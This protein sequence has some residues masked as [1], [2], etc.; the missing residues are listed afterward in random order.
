MST[1]LIKDILNTKIFKLYLL[2]NKLFNYAYYFKWVAGIVSV[3]AF[4]DLIIGSGVSTATAYLL[5]L[6]WG[7][8]IL[9]MLF[10]ASVHA[11]TGVKVRVLS[12]K[13]DIEVGILLMQI[14]KLL[15]NE[16]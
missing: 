9:F 14:D 2:I 4:L 8:G 11:L 3:I 10:S 6:T 16:N 7:V 15:S 5:S 12:K 13:Y 1:D